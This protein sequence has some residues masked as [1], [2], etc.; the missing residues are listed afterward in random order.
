MR[1]RRAALSLLLL[2]GLAAEASAAAVE[3]HYY[4]WSLGGFLGTIA[5]IFIPGDGDGLLTI[6]TLPGGRERGELRVTSNESNAGEYFV[7][8]SEWAPAERRT[9]RAWSDLVWR[10]EKKSKQ[11]D[12]VDENVLDVVAAIQLLR[13][14]RPDHPVRLEIWSD[15]RLYPVVVLPRETEK[16]RLPGRDVKARHYD[17]HGINLPGRR[18]WKGELDLWIADD[19]AATP[20]EI[21]VS[22]KGARVRLMLVDPPAGKAPDGAGSHP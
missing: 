7:Y 10:G 22:R 5:S 13:A 3:R 19:A 2:A 6:E 1:T 11:A 8:G 9:L 4:R 15:G 18:Q 14:E 21:T 16:R 20:V 17:V 12:L